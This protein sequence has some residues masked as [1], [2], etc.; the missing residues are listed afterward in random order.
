MFDSIISKPHLWFWHSSMLTM[1]LFC[2]TFKKAIDL[3]FHDT[4]FVLATVHV[5]MILS[6]YLSILGYLYYLLRK[7]S[8]RRCLTVIHVLS[9]LILVLGITLFF[10]FNKTPSLMLT[11]LYQ[12][13]FV[14]ILSVF[15]LSKLILLVNIALSLKA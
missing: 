12:E 13:V 2:T 1:M 14:F 6:I 3:Q 5:G 9:T 8:L 10:L 7:L 4:Y 15:L 11:S